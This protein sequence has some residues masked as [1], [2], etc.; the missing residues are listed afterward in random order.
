[1]D[2]W[3]PTSE[4]Q[5]RS[6]IESG[7]ISESHYFELKRELGTTDGGRK[8]TARDLASFALDGGVIIVGVEEPTSG[9]FALAPIPLS[10][11]SERV[12]Q[13]AANRIEPGLFVRTS[14]IA[15]PDHPGMG[16]L[17][18]EVPPSTVAPHM[19]DGRYWGRNEKT[20]RHLSEPE[21]FRLHV[22]RTATEDRVRAALAEE[23]D[24]DPTPRPNARMFLVAVPL[25]ADA[26][27]ARLFV[28]A[29]HA[30][31]NNFAGVAEGTLPNSLLSAST[32][33]HSLHATVARSR[34]IARTN[35]MDARTVKDA[36]S[37]EWAEDIEVQLNGSIRIMTSE[38][39]YREEVPRLGGPQPFVRPGHL[40]AW[41]HRLI[42]YAAH[43]GQTLG[44]RGS[45]GLGV[46]IYGLTGA[47]A[48]FERGRSLRM[49]IYEAA[50][51]EA[52]TAAQLRE[53]TSSPNS[54][55]DHL[56]GDLIHQLG[57]ATEFSEALIPEQ[58]APR[59]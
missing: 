37:A 31:M 27:L 14:E 6:A 11:I 1:M 28:R 8:E 35:L 49:Q 22:S 42:G 15:S 18:I 59:S 12:E 26:G 32:S 48:S 21:V 45:W 57:V 46:H 13:I 9:R 17:V 2:L 24:R 25:Q 33:P 34:G 29:G 7:S 53:L 51:F 16:Y 56:I 47:R 10:D 54:V 4:P 50:V 5:L 39:F 38:F 20:K 43:L 52:I 3:L 23:L 19:V 41:T 58:S 55:A 30:Q 36:A 40:L 44:Y